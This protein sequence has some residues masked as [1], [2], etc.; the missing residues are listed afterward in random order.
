MTSPGRT[1]YPFQKDDATNSACLW[2]VFHCLANAAR[3]DGNPQ[4]T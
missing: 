3:S 2:R 1:L 4:V